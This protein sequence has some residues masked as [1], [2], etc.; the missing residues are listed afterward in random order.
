MAELWLSCA[1]L[2]ATA[3]RHSANRVALYHSPPRPAG[4]P[5]LQCRCTHHTLPFSLPAVAAI[6]AQCSAGGN[7][8]VEGFVS[9]RARKHF[10]S[11][12]PANAQMLLHGPRKVR[13]RRTSTNLS[14]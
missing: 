12:A 11:A 7:D 4:P 2:A 13:F 10:T 6:E 14:L 1:A 8:T 5:N 3:G 9:A